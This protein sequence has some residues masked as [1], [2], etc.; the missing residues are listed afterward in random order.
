MSGN[1]GKCKVWQNSSCTQSGLKF[2]WHVSLTGL[3]SDVRAFIEFFSK[4]EKEQ[5]VKLFQKKK[6]FEMV[7]AA[8]IWFLIG[9]FFS[10][11]PS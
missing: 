10:I 6:K 8:D 7:F 2:C 11:K 9:C 4:N 3:L 5:V 1:I